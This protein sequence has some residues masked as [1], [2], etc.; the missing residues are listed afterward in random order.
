M[1]FIYWTDIPVEVD[2]I[3]LTSDTEDSDTASDDTVTFF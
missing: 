3:D 2:L 1:F